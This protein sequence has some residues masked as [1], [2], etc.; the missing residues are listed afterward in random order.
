M[1]YIVSRAHYDVNGVLTSRCTQERVGIWF[2][3]IL[4]GVATVFLAL[5]RRGFRLEDYLMQDG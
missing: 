3:F 5:M 1:T 2:R 4:E